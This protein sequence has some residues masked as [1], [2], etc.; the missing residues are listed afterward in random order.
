MVIV[1]D[2]YPDGEALKAMADV[3][4]DRP[5]L[6]VLVIGHVEPNLDVLVAM[7]SGAF[8]YLPPLSEPARG[9][10]CR[11]RAPAG[12]AVLPRA[13]SFPLVQHLRWG[14]RGII[15]TS[16]DGRPVELTNREVG[17]PRAPAPGPQHR[18][19]RH[20]PRGL[21]RHDPHPRR[22]ARAQA[23][24]QRPQRVDGVAVL[25][26]TGRCRTSAP[27]GRRPSG[28]SGANTDVSGPEW[29]DGRARSWRASIR[30]AA[31][32]K[33]HRADRFESGVHQRMGGSA[34]TSGR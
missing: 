3:T 16:L 20:P 33:R 19:D 12:D 8:G 11:R 17:S 6:G 14:G 4:T 10:R 30:R 23:R 34:P 25:L 5:D 29:P 31:M 13:M 2:G 28:R 18:R 1:L 21:E 15:V 32:S 7:A 22:R 9:R 27:C 24:R 26:R